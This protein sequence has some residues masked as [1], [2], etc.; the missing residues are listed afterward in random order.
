MVVLV[1]CGGEPRGARAPV[2]APVLAQPSDAIPGDLDLVVRLD[3]GRIRQVLGADALRKLRERAGFGPDAEHEDAL[4]IDSLERADTAWLGLRLAER[5]EL[6]DSVL[7]VRGN[8]RD[9]DVRS[10]RAEPGWSG[11]RDLGGGWRCFEREPRRRS[12]PARAYARLDE[13]FVFVTPAE[14]DSVER[15]LERGIR[16][17]HPTPPERGIVSLAARP[18][19]FSAGLRQRAPAAARFLAK[20]ERLEASADLAADRLKVEIAM[21]MEDEGSARRTADATGLLV[22]ELIEQGAIPKLIARSLS[23]EAVGTSVV[24]GLDAPIELLAVASP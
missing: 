1:A 21:T 9:M 12:S 19:A 13:L 6:V 14:I 17:A 23:V 5:R 15:V 24:V 4:I 8:F 20:S 7:I 10:Y 18:H 3:L 22:L 2:P 11:Q 16:D